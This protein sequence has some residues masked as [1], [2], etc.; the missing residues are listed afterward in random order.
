[1]HCVDYNMYRRLNMENEDRD[2]IVELEDQETGERVSFVLADRFELNGSSYVVLIT[3]EDEDEAEMVIMEETEEEGGEVLLKTLDEDKEDVIYD[4][5]DDLCDE[6]FEDI[7][8]DEDE[9]N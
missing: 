2:Y 4:Y 8:D 5:Y 7:D 9:E 1:M 3:D 6:M